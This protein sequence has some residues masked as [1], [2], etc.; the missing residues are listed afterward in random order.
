MGRTFRPSCPPIPL[1]NIE[2]KIITSLWSAVAGMVD[3]VNRLAGVVNAIADRA[4]GKI[5]LTVAKP[6]PITVDAKAVAVNG[7]RKAVKA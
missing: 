3:A 4:E 2:M 5:R 7:H 6:A 1:E